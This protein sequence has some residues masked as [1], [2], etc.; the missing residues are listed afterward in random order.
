M[1]N[2]LCVIP[3]R[4]RSTRLPEKLLMPIAGKPLLYYTWQ[5][6]KKAACLRAVVIATDSEK[7]RRAATSFG[8]EV[9]MT[10]ACLTGTDRVAEAARVF[11]NFTPRV[12]VNLQGDEPLMPPEAIDA[13]VKALAGD[14]G[15]SM[16]TLASPLSFSEAE[17]DS[18]VKVA[19]DRNGR[20]LYFSRARIPFP[21]SMYR[22]YLRHI[23]LYAFRMPFLMKYVGLPRT[24]LEI[25]E[26]LEQLRILEHG[27]EIRVATGNF[28]SIGVDVESDF[29]RAEKEIL[30][31]VRH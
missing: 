24:P 30:S 28:K 23:G 29:R 10:G 3:A 27:Y 22:G 26:S 1:K 2:I 19:C 6:A 13:C 25:A 15:A 16:S 5:Q 17:A 20:A 21:R 7:I 12:V 31:H 8:A 4:L 18:T 9:V 14:A 11:G